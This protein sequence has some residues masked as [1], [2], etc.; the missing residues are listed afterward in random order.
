MTMRDYVLEERGIAYRKNDVE[1]GRRTLVLIHGLSSSAS[2]W[3]RYEDAF[4]RRYNVVTVDLRGHGLSTKPRGIASYTIAR[5]AEDVLALLDQLE[6][7]HIVLIG[8]SFGALV[9]LEFLARYQNRV[10]R[11]VLLSPNYKIGR[12][13]TEQILNVALKLSPIFDVLPFSSKPRGR[14]DYTRFLGTGDWNFGRLSADVG[15]TTLRVYIYCT[16]QSYGFDRESCL[17]DITVPVLLM[18]GKKDTIF[19]V[20]NSLHMASRIAGSQLV[21]LDHADHVIVLNNF[22]ELVASISAFVDA[23]PGRAGVPA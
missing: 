12:R 3:A 7:E 17:S 18:H 6:L 10:A 23:E 1:P 16:R 21:L 14:V 9:A 22:A 8:H 19:P 4:A 20:A 5:M 2:A 13:L 11:A 15:N